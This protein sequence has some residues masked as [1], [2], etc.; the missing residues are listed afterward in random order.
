MGTVFTQLQLTSTGRKVF[1][2]WC[3][4]PAEGEAAPV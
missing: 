2:E 1:A 4:S 3:E